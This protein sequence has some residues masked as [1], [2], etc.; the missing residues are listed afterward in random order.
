MEA[1]LRVWPPARFI[2]SGSNTTVRL[3]VILLR[4]GRSRGRRILFVRVRRLWPAHWRQARPRPVFAFVL[5]QPIEGHGRSRCGRGAR[6]AHA[7]KWSKPNAGSN[8]A[9]WARSPPA[10]AKISTV[11]P[12]CCQRI[13]R[14]DLDPTRLLTLSSM[15]RPALRDPARTDSA[16]LI[17]PDQISSAG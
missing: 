14:T 1:R 11:T 7:E 16:A 15:S 5:I 10:T 9:E 2:R 6:R 17:S 4:R 3:P 12:R 8:P 13:I